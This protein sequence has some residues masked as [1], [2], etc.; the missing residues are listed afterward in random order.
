ML[1][2]NQH[3]KFTEVDILAFCPKTKAD[4]IVEVRAR[5]GNSHPPVFWLSSNKVKKLQAVAQL[6]AIKKGSTHRI[7]FVQLL[8]QSM[9]TVS[10]CEGKTDYQVRA[11]LCDFEIDANT[12]A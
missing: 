11:D 2:R 9:Q 8:I 1:A 10:K 4:W 6:L 12:S 5:H 3:F 7:L